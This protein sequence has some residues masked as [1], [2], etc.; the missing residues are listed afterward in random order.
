MDVKAKRKYLIAFTLLLLV[1]FA[2]LFIL[3]NKKVV[4]MRMS[5]IPI[6]QQITN[7]AGLSRMETGKAMTDTIMNL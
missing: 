5:I 4:F 7:V 2:F 3:D 1:A 6:T